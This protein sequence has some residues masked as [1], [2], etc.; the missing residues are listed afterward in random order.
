MDRSAL[1]DCA[2][3]GRSLLLADA[4]S[5]KLR[6]QVFAKSVGSPEPELPVRLAV[7][8]DRAGLGAR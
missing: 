7:A 8:I 4:H 1:G 5:A 3:E 2:P 6:R